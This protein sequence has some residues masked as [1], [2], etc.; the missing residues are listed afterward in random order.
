[1]P[2]RR[3][4]PRRFSSSPL[5][6]FIFHAFHFGIDTMIF[7]PAISS[8]R[9]SMF[10]F[11]RFFFAFL[12]YFF[13]FFDITLIPGCCQ[14]RLRHASASASA[15]DARLSYA[16]RI[17]ASQ[18]LV[19]PLS[20]A[21]MPCCSFAARYARRVVDSALSF[22]SMLMITK[23]THYRRRPASPDYFRRAAIFAAS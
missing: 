19:R 3:F 1:M 12:H 2:F 21:P 22:S 4:S 6:F 17:S 20:L 23:C 15:S 7:S 16:T 8:L 10:H 18:A 13:I 11:L 5:I 9:F 14:R